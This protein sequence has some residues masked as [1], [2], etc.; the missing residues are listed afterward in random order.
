M[1]M[2]PDDPVTFD[3]EPDQAPEESYQISH[4][5]TGQSS[6]MLERYHPA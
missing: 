5:Y 6:A 2:R 3:S 4:S 1:E